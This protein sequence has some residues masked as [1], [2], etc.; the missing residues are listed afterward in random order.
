MNVIT[1]VDAKCLHVVEGLHDV[2]AVWIKTA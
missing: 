2:Q 1:P